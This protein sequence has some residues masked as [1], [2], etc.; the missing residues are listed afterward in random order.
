MEA[1]PGYSLHR[2]PD[3]DLAEGDWQMRN[4]TLL[5]PLAQAESHDSAA[6]R[7]SFVSKCSC[8]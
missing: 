4:Q 1:L 2:D 6:Q 3:H 8:P 7:L 5:A